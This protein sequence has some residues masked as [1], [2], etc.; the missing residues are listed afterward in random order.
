MI[1]SETFK[2]RLV[3]VA[4]DEAHCISEWLVCISNSRV[5]NLYCLILV[6]VRIS[7]RTLKR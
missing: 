6:G 4:V 5:V 7:E 2:A 3:L 1:S